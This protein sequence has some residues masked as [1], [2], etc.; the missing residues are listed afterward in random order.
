MLGL[1][2]AFALMLQPAGAFIVVINEIM[3]HPSVAQGDIEYIELFN[4]TQLAVDLSGWQFT[5]G[6]EY[7][8]PAGTWIPAQGYI[9][10]VSS[11]TVFQAAYPAVA[12]LGPYTGQLSN[13]GEEI[14]L[15]NANGGLIDTVDYNDRGRWPVAADGTGHSLSLVHSYL[16]NSDPEAWSIS[17]T[18]GGTPGQMNFPGNPPSRTVVINEVHPNPAAGDGWIELHNPTGSAVNVTGWWLSNNRNTLQ[19]Y[20]IPATPPLA[21]GGFLTYTSSTLGFTLF[22]TGGRVFLTNPVGTLVMHAVDY[23][24]VAVGHSDGLYFDARNHR[25]DWYYMTTPTP[26][27]ANVVDIQDDIV[28]NEIMYSPFDGRPNREY[29]ELYNRGPSAVELTGWRFSNGVRYRFTTGTTIA[30]GGYLVLAESTATI[31]SIYGLP[32]SQVVGP[33][34]RTLGDDRDRVVLRDQY[35]NI[36]DEVRYFDG[37]RWP[38]WA[39][40][41]GSSLELIDYN[42]SNNYPSAWAASDDSAKAVW[43]SV[44]YTK[45]QID[46]PVRRWLGGSNYTGL[47]EPEFHVMLS[48]DGICLIDDLSMSLAAGGPDLITNGNF[49]AGTSGWKI[50]GTHKYSSPVSGPGNVHGGSQALRIVAAGRGT[51]G[52]DHIETATVADPRDVLDLA[53]EPVPG[54]DYTVSYWAKW[55]VGTNQLLTRTHYHGVAQTTPLPVPENLGTPGQQNSRYQANLG[56]IIA[57][58]DQTPVTPR[59]TQ[60]VTVTALVLDSNG[61]TNVRLY[62][63]RDTAITWSNV[64]MFDD[65]AHGDGA[66][67]DDVYGG[68]IPAIAHNNND[69]MEFYIRATDGAAAW[70]TFPASTPPTAPPPKSALYRVRDTGRGTVLKACELLINDDVADFIAT[71]ER[72]DNELV[73]GTFTLDDQFIFY[74]VRWRVKGS[75]YTRPGGWPSRPSYRVRFNSDQQFFDLISVNFD[76][77]EAGGPLNDRL[78]QWLMYKLGEV[79]V[80]PREY[81]RMFRHATRDPNR[82]HGVYE[83]QKRVDK[84]FVDHYYRG[85]GNDGF[86]HK[87]D[88]HFEW[89]DSGNFTRRGQDTAHLNYY[90]PD[91]EWYRWQF[92]PRT[93]EIEDDF[94]SLITMIQF[95]DPDETDDA[96]WEAGVE[97]YLETTEWLKKLAASALTDDWDTLGL[98]NQRGKNCSIYVRS[99]TKKWVLIPWDSDLSFGNCYASIWAHPWFQSCDRLMRY[100]RYGRLYLSY[101]QQLIDGPFSAAQ[102]NAE[103]DRIAVLLTA[104]GV[105][106]NAAALK[107]WATCRRDHLLTSVL[108]GG[109]LFEITTNGGNDFAIDTPTVDLQGTG[110]LDVHSFKVKVDPGP[111]LPW[112]NSAWIDIQ[113]WQTSTIPVSLGPNLITV[114]GHDASGTTVGIDSITVTVYPNLRTIPFGTS[115]EPTETPPFA[116]GPLPQNLWDGKG[117]IQ[118]TT[119]Y[120]GVQAVGLQEGYAQHEFLGAGHDQVWVQS[121]VRTAGSDETPQISNDVG[122]FATQL[123]FSSSQGILALDGNGVGGGS[124]VSSGVPLDA[125]RFIAIGIWLDYTTQRWDLYIDGNPVLTN[126]GFA[127]PR[128]HMSLLR[129]YS[130]VS[131]YLDLVTVTEKMG[132]ALEIEHWQLY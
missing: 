39:D 81:V 91:E 57:N 35:D 78:V 66:A 9:V 56:P 43:T 1:L 4:D 17:S 129:Y 25:E 97:N 36:V 70:Q 132:K 44:T 48:D 28:I 12:A 75:G 88:D 11:P 126:L 128:T 42:Q 120:E 20:Q 64:Q 69:L 45:A 14:D 107:N 3:Y 63:K 22:P 94:T 121:Y 112:P 58:V 130:D 131:G 96:T 16:S 98:T 92:K 109:V 30:S 114:T 33:T 67:G 84:A 118:N 24:D 23:G 5:D 85:V 113:T 82:N 52:P 106:A 83:H 8:F 38:E 62:Y 32:L 49:E 87:V 125:G 50:G 29:I 99:D 108:P 60:N 123:F 15:R 46:L 18:I 61:V 79:P 40:G 27:A 2:A 31:V 80:S 124:W 105:G 73:D 90:G 122:A 54:A 6:V 104:E 74:N 77:L 89:S 37:G 7:T 41:F 72:M 116:L 34:S 111:A 102:F 95:M 47:A 103:V 110:G 21:S 68:V 101:I 76:N 65:G 55:V 119:V 100:G 86:L 13:T 53:S 117:D 10:V 59:S 127:S 19:M 51:E 93:R 71:R 115:F 26:G